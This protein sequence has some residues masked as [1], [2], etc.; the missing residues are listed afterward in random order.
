MEKNV[1]LGFEPQKNK[2]TKSID[3]VGKAEV[4]AV[5]DTIHAR[6]G[7]NG[8]KRY[9]WITI[10][11]R[12]FAGETVVTD[13]THAVT[14]KTPTP[15][16]GE[17]IPVSYS[18]RDGKTDFR[19]YFGDNRLSKTAM[20]QD[21]ADEAFKGLLDELFADEEDLVKAEPTEATE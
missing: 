21:L 18:Y 13:C 4:T 9:R 14:D 10:S 1:F 12:N 5:S 19:R 8:T 2:V 17:T 15:V 6:D 7:K 11:L 20:R 16:V 3:W